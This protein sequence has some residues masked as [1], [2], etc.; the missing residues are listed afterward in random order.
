MDGSAHIESNSPIVEDLVLGTRANPPSDF[1]GETV[2]ESM[3][4]VQEITGEAA[5]AALMGEAIH[6]G[7]IDGVPPPDEPA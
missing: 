2:V 4:K 7:R 6:R 1:L 3:P 5:V